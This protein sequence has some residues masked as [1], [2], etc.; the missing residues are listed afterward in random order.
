[1]P[2]TDAPKEEE[3]EE[4]AAGAAEAESVPLTPLQQ[5]P[6]PSATPF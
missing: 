5:H 6:L 3:E 4:A 1:M 2:T